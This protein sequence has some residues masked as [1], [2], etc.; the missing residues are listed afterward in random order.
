MKGQKNL[1][2]QKNN[3]SPLI[4]KAK[5]AFSN[6][7]ANL[8]KA[9]KNG[10]NSQLFQEINENLRVIGEITTQLEQEL[11]EKKWKSI[12]KEYK[13]YKGEK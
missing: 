7:Y 13:K 2:Y 4:N 8:Q 1:I 11:Q 5:L 10:Y 12:Q 9:K 6:Y 3:N